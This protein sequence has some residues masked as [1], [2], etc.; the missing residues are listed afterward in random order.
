MQLEETL[1]LQLEAKKK[2]HD[3]TSFFEAMSKE[4]DWRGIK[5]KDKYIHR[6]ELINGQILEKTGKE[7]NEFLREKKWAISA[8]GT[9]FDQSTGMGVL[10]QTLTF[11]Y[12]ERK[13]L[14]AEVTKWKEILEDLLKQHEK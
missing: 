7:W 5:D 6:A 13:K 11:W 3:L 8:Y 12:A 4:S 1:D 14:Q 2:G 10:P 9:I